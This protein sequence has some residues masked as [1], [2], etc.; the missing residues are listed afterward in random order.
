MLTHIDA[1]DASDPNHALTLSRDL[2]PWTGE[3]LFAVTGE[4]PEEER[5]TL[6]G[7]FLTKA[8][9]GPYS[10]TRDWFA[11]LQD[12]ARKTGAAP[13]QVWFYYTTCPTCAKAY[14]QNHVIGLVEL[15]PNHTAPA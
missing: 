13:G 3:H 5:V 2:S 8:F 1:R 14:G 11:A 15:L 7:D 10:K 4:V 9:E 12:A 6:S